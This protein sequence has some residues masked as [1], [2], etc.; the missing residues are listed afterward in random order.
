MDANRRAA[1]RAVRNNVQIA[2]DASRRAAQRIVRN[3]AQIALENA[4]H[5][6]AQTLLHSDKQQET[7]NTDR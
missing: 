1:Q 5:V 3:D 2:T 7:R 6:N 4:T